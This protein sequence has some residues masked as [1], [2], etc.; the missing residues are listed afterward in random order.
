VRENGATSCVAIGAQKEGE[1]C[2]TAHCAANLVCLGTPGERTCF[3]LCHILT[4]AECSASQQQTCKGGLPL[5]QD[6]S[7]GICQ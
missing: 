3:Q 2:D 5:F 6:N 4:G 7:I 1:A